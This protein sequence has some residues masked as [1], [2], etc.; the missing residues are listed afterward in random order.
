M[1]DGLTRTVRSHS[2]NLHKWT[3]GTNVFHRM[4]L[5][6]FSFT[7][8]ACEGTE[9]HNPSLRVF[10]H[11]VDWGRGRWRDVYEEIKE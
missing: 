1:F 3:N 9:T 2:G 8:C 11:F 10:L 7:F 4:S 5:S 6:F